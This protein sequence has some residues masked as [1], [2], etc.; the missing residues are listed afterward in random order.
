VIFTKS[1]L[2][3]FREKISQMGLDGALVLKDANR[4]Y[5][6]RYNGEESALIV[7]SKDAVFIT[8]S[9]YREEA[10][11]E[12]YGFEVREYTGSMT[13]FLGEI[14][15][16]LGIKRLGFEENLITYKTYKELTRL[17]EGIELAPLE[18]TIEK[19]RQVKDLEEISNIEKAAAIAD[20][21]FAHMLEFIHPGMTEVEIGLELEYYMKSRGASKLSFDPVIASGK[22]SSFPHGR[23]TH[24]VVEAGDFLTMDF[25]CMYNGY[26]S[27]MTR[28]I[29]IG[30]ASQKQK[31][32]YE[33]VLNANILALEAARPGITGE[34]LDAAA[35][36]YIAD[37]GYGSYF[38]H[39]L[40]H[41]VGLEIHELPSI[42]KKGKEPLEP[43]M[44]IT[45]EPGIYIP[46]F[47][48]VRIE[49][50]VVI[51]EDGCRVLSKSNKKL[52]E[53]Y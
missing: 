43:F 49:D 21:G 53:L 47:C 36:K 42:S 52:I 50:L 27:D 11:R 4:N 25:G 3:R 17:I 2:S 5:L 23:A 1:R 31:E 35:R 51:T 48:G 34:E 30:M 45:D 46:D 39:S 29:V 22:R 38:G 10:E 37:R 28:T 44:V 40:G 41:G 16:D 33:I 14:T 19:L 15:R 12:A 9:R 6:T 20:E 13:A 24:K 7:T 8:D 18:G 26:C 32:I